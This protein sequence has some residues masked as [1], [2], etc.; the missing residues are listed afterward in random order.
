M[1]DLYGIVHPPALLYFRQKL[2]GLVKQR[3]N[4]VC[5]RFQGLMD[6]TFE[7]LSVT[8]DECE[9]HVTQQIENAV[10]LA[11]EFMGATNAFAVMLPRDVLAPIIWKHFE[12]RFFEHLHD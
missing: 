1:G 3:V 10:Q 7:V 6:Q 4:S 2:E 12:C 11:T 5:S 9:A 8:L